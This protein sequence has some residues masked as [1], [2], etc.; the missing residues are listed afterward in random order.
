M[1]IEIWKCDKCGA[2]RG[3]D[4]NMRYIHLVI[5]PKN[6]VN[7]FQLTGNTVSTVLWCHDCLDSCELMKQGYWNILT[8]EEREKEVKPS[9]FGE[10]LS[11]LFT[12]E[13]SDEVTDQ[14]SDR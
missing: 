6:V 13:I 5:S 8:E 10:K 3:N 4:S 7:K 1:K 14:L 11:E 2:E 12:V 9:S